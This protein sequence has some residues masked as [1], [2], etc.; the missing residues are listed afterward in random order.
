M[1]VEEYRSE[2]IGVREWYKWYDQPMVE[3]VPNNATPQQ[4]QRD[5][6]LDQKTV[7]ADKLLS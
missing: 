4:P 7:K 6:Y 1:L 2:H 3:P 5:Q